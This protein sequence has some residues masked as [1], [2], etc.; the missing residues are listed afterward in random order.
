MFCYASCLYGF[1]CNFDIL[2]E[3]WACP[4]HFFFFKQKTAYEMSISDWSSDGC[5]S[6]LRLADR[7]RVEGQAVGLGR[8]GQRGRREADVAA[9]DDDGGRAGVGLGPLERSLERVEVLGDLADL[10]DV[11]AVAAEA[12][13]GV[14]G[15][16]QLGGAVDGDVVVVV[17]HDQLVEALVA[18][19]G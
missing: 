3:V 15:E 13:G 12:G 7:V 1:A 11:P 14:V 2:A 4:P 5:S 6:D 17:D 8:I 16:R 10:V 19:A 18:G 9:Q